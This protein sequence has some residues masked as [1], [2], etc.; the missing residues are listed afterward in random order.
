MVYN[1]QV[2]YDLAAIIHCEHASNNV[3]LYLTNYMGFLQKQ[4][5]NTIAFQC[6]IMYHTVFGIHRVSSFRILSEV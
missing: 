1:M 2:V 5:D 4:S 6:T 3:F